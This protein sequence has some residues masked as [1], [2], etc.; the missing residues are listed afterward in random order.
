MASLNDSETRG[1]D[2]L[3]LKSVLDILILV[4]LI[5]LLIRPNEAF[6]H[7]VYR[8]IYRLTDPVLLPARH[9]TRTA[10]QGVTLTVVALAVLRGALYIAI[11]GRTLAS[12][13]NTSLQELL[14]LLFQG[15]MVLWV[16]AALGGRGYGSFLVH[17]MARALV[18]VDA[19]LRS[20]GI[21][22]GGFVAGSFVL[23]WMAYAVAS[24]VFFSVLE[25]QEFPSPSLLARALAHGL[26][27]F[28]YLFPFPGFFSLVIIIGALLSWVSPD[29]S[30]PVVQAIYGIS[31]PLLTP[32]RRIVPHLGGLDISPILALVAFQVLGGIAQQL[33]ASALRAVD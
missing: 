24:L 16:V 31:E 8:L 20:M 30:N 2:M 25:V 18:P 23:L 13:L 5:R 11:E 9:V 10:A 15:Y 27:L 32:F 14:G 1:G 21:R 19:A 22:R 29:R 28:I 6:F 3:F 12:G 7:P 4:L 26:L 17:L 33:V